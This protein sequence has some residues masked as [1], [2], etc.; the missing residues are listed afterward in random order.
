MPLFNALSL[1]LIL[2]IS[3]VVGFIRHGCDQ[4]LCS[5][6]WVIDRVFECTSQIE[7]KTPLPKYRYRC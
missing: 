5:F 1:A 2:S 7:V 3:I 6:T 4:G